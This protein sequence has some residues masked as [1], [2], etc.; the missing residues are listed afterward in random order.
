M[1]SL[2]L[3]IFITFCIILVLTQQISSFP[4]PQQR[5]D[6]AV[7]EALDYLHALDAAYSQSGRPR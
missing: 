1:A 5:N 7:A 2:T 3:R 4:R 6:A